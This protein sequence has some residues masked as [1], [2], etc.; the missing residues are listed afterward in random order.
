M[1]LQSHIQHQIKR[2]YKN[3]PIDLSFV[4][5]KPTEV[6][7]EEYGQALV[8]TYPWKYEVVEQS[9]HEVPVTPKE[10]QATIDDAAK[11]ENKPSKED[12]E[13]GTIFNLEALKALADKLEVQYAPNI[14]RATLADRLVNVIYPE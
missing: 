8:N 10:S 3:E 1:F 7:N 14:G 12:L 2:N 13:N 5:G 6:T 4:P 11:L 9:A